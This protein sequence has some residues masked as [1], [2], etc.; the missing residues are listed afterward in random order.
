[1]LEIG[2]GH[3]PKPRSDV[4]CDKFI[5]DNQQRGGHL[6]V[7]RPL[8]EGDGQYL[9]FVD[10]AFDY[11]ICCHVLEHVEDP[12]RFIGEL[13]RVATRGY[14]ETP[15]EIAE[16]IYGWRYHHWL[17][18]HIDA[19]LVLQKKREKSQFGELFHTLVARDKQWKRFHLTHHHLF[20]VQYE[21][22]DDINYELMQAEK[23]PIN[24]SCQK[25]LETLMAQSGRNGNAWMPILKNV[26]PSG[27]V[28]RVKSIL[29]KR[30]RRRQTK[31]LH[32]ILACPHCKATM[33]WATDMLHCQICE[34]HY[35]I[36]NGIPRLAV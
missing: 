3:N 7:D 22:E 5:D 30:N 21:W 32:E 19:K 26:L 10:G 20:L 14:I 1:M 31:R 35:P 29:A 16:R 27:M 4:L 18:N 12:V 6:V 33:N 8:V 2:S 9:P 34:K 24:L 36:I 11:V 25:A 28:A 13:M 23:S 17:I 15:S